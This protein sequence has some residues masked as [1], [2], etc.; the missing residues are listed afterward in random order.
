MK[1][2]DSD[3]GNVGLVTLSHRHPFLV[4]TLAVSNLFI[5]N[6]TVGVP[7]QVRILQIGMPG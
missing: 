2:R 3:S 5:T 4:P 6:R 7:S 1:F